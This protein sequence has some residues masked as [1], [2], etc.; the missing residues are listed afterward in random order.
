MA[1]S[2]EV[3][4]S[5]LMRLKEQ[6]EKASLKVNIQK[7][8]IKASGPITSWQIEEE[9]AEAVTDFIFLGSQTTADDDCSYE[10]KRLLTGESHGQRSLAGYSP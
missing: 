9:K 6:R 3:L 10:V 4:K 8:K 7:V 5:L 2:K 1:E